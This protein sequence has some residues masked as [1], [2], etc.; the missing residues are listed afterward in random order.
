MPRTAICKNNDNCIRKGREMSWPIKC[1]ICKKKYCNRDS[2]LRNYNIET[3][4]MYGPNKEF[5]IHNYG[6]YKC[7]EHF[8]CFNCFDYC[9]YCE[10]YFCKKCNCLCN[11]PCY[12]CNREA[13]KDIYSKNHFCYKCNKSV[14][15]NC[16]NKYTTELYEFKIK[17][18]YNLIKD[19][20]MQI[21]CNSC[22]D[23]KNLF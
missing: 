11:S 19:Y 22:F 8:I 3:D 2:C 23:N 21:I 4:T 7:N 17:Y 15:N 9:Q 10:K 20:K 16:S 5:I 14:C 1:I 12:F 18:N 13:G 6:C